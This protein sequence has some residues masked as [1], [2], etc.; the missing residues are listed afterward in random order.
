MR[1]RIVLSYSMFRAGPALGMRCHARVFDRMSDDQLSL[2]LTNGQKLAAA[3]ARK[4][5]TEIVT[6]LIERAGRFRDMIDRCDAL[7]TGR[8][9]EWMHVRINDDVLEVNIGDAAKQVKN[10]TTEFR[11]LLAEI[12]R[13]RANV[14][15]DGEDDD[16][17][18]DD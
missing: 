10:L 7:I 9:S 8:R 15:A 3:L 16:V 11:Q 18:D 6:Q 13:Q 14:S 5:D 2:E 4:G 12:N 17:L 1:L